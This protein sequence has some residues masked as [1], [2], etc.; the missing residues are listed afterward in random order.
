VLRQSQLLR[1]QSGL[2]GVAPREQT[3]LAVEFSGTDGAPIGTA[4]VTAPDNRTTRTGLYALDKADLF[5][6]L[7]IPPYAPDAD[8]DVAND[9]KPAADYCRERRA[10]LIIDAPAAWTVD[11]AAEN[12]KAFRAVA[13]RDG[14]LYFPRVLAPD[15]FDAGKPGTYAPCGAVAGV[16]SRVDAASGVWKA[17]ANETLRG[18]NGPSLNV[19]SSAQSRLDPL[20]INCLRDFPDR[21]FRIWGARTLDNSQ[22]E[23]KYVNVRRF[24][25]YIEQSIDRGTQWVVFEPNDESTWQRVRQAI[26]TF[27]YGLWRAGALMGTKPDQ[28]FFVKCDRTTMTPDDIQNGRLVAVIGLAIVRPAEFVILK[29]SQKAGAAS[30]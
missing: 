23:W 20:G 22:P 12:V 28:A 29:F 25:L 10:F 19:N 13:Q 24:F 21:G 4:E 7:C 11:S 17:P 3:A 30:P 9:W 5:N 26:N 15:P 27:L 6:L 18:V 2:R 1:L 14:A 8:L 16:M